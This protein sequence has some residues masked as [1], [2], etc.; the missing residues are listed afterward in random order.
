MPHSAHQQGVRM[1][2]VTRTGWGIPVDIRMAWDR[3]DIPAGTR[4]GLRSAG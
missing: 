1:G 3:A 2:W 4:R